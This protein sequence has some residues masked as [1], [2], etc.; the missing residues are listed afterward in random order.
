MQLS[1]A[2]KR[3]LNEYPV[4][5][6]QP[7]PANPVAA[8]VRKDLPELIHD[9][10]Q[11]TSDYLIEGSAGPIGFL[12]IKPGGIHAFRHG[13]ITIMDRL[14]VPLKLRTQRVGQSHSSLTLDVY[15]HVASEDDQRLAEQ[16]GRILR[17][18]APKKGNGLE[19]ETPKPL[20][21]N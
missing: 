3:I 10:S 13:N 9:V 12:G 8:F 19:V 17:P 5:M 4:A 6:T 7:F 21:L 20:F 18:N 16:L 1:E 2:F 14:A 15:T 11:V